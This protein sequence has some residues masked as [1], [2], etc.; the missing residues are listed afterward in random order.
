VSDWWSI[1]TIR[2]RA[3]AHL[4][5]NF[6]TMP[7]SENITPYT[8]FASS[9]NDSLLIGAVATGGVLAGM[10]GGVDEDSPTA[11]TTPEEYV[12]VFLGLVNST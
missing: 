10:G 5:D 9:S 12:R 11:T 2:E 8:S 6:C 1:N 4:P 7:L 3:F